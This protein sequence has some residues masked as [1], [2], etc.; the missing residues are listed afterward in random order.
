MIATIS[1]GS[2]WSATDIAIGKVGK[3]KSDFFF[4]TA[5]KSLDYKLPKSKVENG[6]VRP[7]YSSMDY[8]IDNEIAKTIELAE[9][10]QFLLESDLE[11]LA[12]KTESTSGGLK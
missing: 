4:A 12:K 6:L 2:D 11:I 3:G 8:R 9:R 5:S 1:G 10:R 7:I